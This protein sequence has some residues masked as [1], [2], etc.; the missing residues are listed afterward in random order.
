[1]L[2]LPYI[3]SS[4]AL[5]QADSDLTIHGRTD[6]ERTPVRVAINGADGELFA[7]AETAADAEGRFSAT[8]PT[9]PASFSSYTISVTD[10]EESRVM[11]DVLFGE[12][13]LASGQSNME[14]PN[15]FIPDA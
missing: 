9:P 7:S 11:Q 14:L 2:T 13:W 8:L 12:L 3:F 6:P 10:R 15:A 5:F 1:M 4:G